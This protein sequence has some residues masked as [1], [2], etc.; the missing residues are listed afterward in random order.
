MPITKSDFN[1][2]KTEFILSEV[3]KTILHFLMAHPKLAFTKHELLTYIRIDPK[4][5]YPLDFDDYTSHL[6]KFELLQD[7]SWEQ[8]AIIENALNF[9]FKAGLI[10]MK[11]VKCVPHRDIEARKRDEDYYMTIS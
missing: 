1:K 8:L 9:L 4:P 5:K 10:Q 3:E 7:R 2:G 11:N 6:F